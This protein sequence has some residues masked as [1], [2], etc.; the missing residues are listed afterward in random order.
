MGEQERP[1]V[2]SRVRCDGSFGVG[3][4]DDPQASLPNRKVASEESF[5]WKVRPE[6]EIFE[7]DIY[8]DGSA[9]NGPAAELIRC[10]SPL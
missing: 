8:P 7:G 2:R 4:G 3:E 1:N 10:G 9:W 5:R 6:G